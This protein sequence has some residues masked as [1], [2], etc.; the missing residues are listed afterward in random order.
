MKSRCYYTG[1]IAYKNYGGRGIT[2]C[3]K[4]IHD[5]LVFRDWA[6]THGYTEELT[7]DRKDNNGNYSPENCKWSTPKEQANN[8]RYN[9]RITHEGQTK[10]VAEW[11]EILGV[12]RS[13][14]YHLVAKKKPLD[15]IF[16]TVAGE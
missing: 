12:R 13:I 16:S 1:N 2:V 14:I 10:T 4:W 15:D 11:S 6:L 7:I 9:V 3:E 8:T 5:F